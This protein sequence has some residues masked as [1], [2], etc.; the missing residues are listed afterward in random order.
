MQF[1]YTDRKGFHGTRD[2]VFEKEVP[3]R[4]NTDSYSVCGRKRSEV[5]CMRKDK[6]RIIGWVMMFVV[7]AIVV[8]CF[9]DIKAMVNEVMVEQAES[10]VD[11]LL[12]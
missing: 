3:G 12:R 4:E 2:G 11:Q 7:I 6:L 5:R 8:I 10:L 9:D 1:L